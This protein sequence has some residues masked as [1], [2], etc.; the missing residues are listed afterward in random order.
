MNK[1]DISKKNQA[2]EISGLLLSGQ[3]LE[4]FKSYKKRVQSQELIS[5][6]VL[7]KVSPIYLLTKKTV[8]KDVLFA[9][10][11]IPV[12]DWVVFGCTIL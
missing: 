12:C 6:N 1:G 2:M 8:P 4:E 11:S 3:V 9:S 7:I 10:I 5:R